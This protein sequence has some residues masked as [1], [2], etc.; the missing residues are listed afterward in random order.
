MVESAPAIK[1]TKGMKIGDVD[2]RN[3]CDAYPCFRQGVAVGGGVLEALLVFL[4][5][6]DA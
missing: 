3:S 5:S 6:K 1:V 4:K 2:R